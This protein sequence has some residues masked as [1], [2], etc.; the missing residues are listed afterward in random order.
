VR[1]LDEEGLQRLALHYAGRFATTR[2]K[3][4][5]YLSRKL[6]E[7]GWEGEGAPPVE[8]LIE[9]FAELG[10]VDD[11]AFATARAASLTRRGYGTRRVGQA[12][13]AAGV[14][15]E[16]S[17]PAREESEAAALTAALSFARRRRIGPFAAVKPDRD[18]R[19]KAAAAMLRAGHAIDVVRKIL[20]ATPGD[21]PDLDLA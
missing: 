14:N 6:K 18:G 19:Q 3:L 15:E 9:R 5:A 10:Y 21:V 8:R 1:P 20:D 2:A 12:L 13:R 7:R 16:D 17:A 11:R 4:S